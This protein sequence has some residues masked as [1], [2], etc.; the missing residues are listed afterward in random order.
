MC[1]IPHHLELA[2][3][4]IASRCNEGLYGNFVARTAWGEG[5]EINR[6]ADHMKN[7]KLYPKP[8]QK[9]ALVSVI[10]FHLRCA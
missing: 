4:K 10:S 2:T 8:S 3:D 7:E 1:D 9:L 5:E 6:D